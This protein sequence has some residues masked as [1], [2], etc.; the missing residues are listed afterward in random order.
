MNKVLKLL[1]NLRVRS[2]NCLN[3]MALMLTMDYTLSTYWRAQASEAEIAYLLFRVVRARCRA[4]MLSSERVTSVCGDATL[5][6][7]VGVM[8][9]IWRMPSWI[10]RIMWRYV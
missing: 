6:L 2:T 1:R 5:A 4:T 7:H 10:S 3:L 8:V 9:L